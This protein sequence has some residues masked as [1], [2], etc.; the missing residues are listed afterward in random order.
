M[1]QLIPEKENIYN[2]SLIGLKTGENLIKLKINENQL[3]IKVNVKV[4]GFIERDLI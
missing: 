3:E 1:Q 2:L 4:G